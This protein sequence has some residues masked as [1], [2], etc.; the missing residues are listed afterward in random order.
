MQ[1]TCG[2]FVFDKNGFVLICCPRGVKTKYD[3]TIPKGKVDKGEEFIDAAIRETREETGLDV[4]PHKRKIKEVGRKKYKH[5]KKKL[6]AFSLFLDNMI[7]TTTLKCECVEK[8]EIVKY[9][10][11]TVKDAI[12][13]LHNVQSHILE[14]YVRE[15]KN[16][17]LSL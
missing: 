11:V 4:S 9:E 7:D 6:V 16:A 3:W 17:I 2:I 10:M 15:S 14:D 12:K 5:K 1:T 13:R 8:P